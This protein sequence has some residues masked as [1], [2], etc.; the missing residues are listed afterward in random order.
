MG[1]VAGGY[2]FGG[3]FVNC[4]S[5]HSFNHR[6]SRLGPTNT[7]KKVNKLLLLN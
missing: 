5:V 3:G 1:H 4:G 6:W 2:G 7:R